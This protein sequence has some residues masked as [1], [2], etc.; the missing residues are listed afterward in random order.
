MACRG[1]EPS[2]SGQDS[3][4][5]EVQKLREREWVWSGRVPCRLAQRRPESGGVPRG[6]GKTSFVIWGGETVPG[7]TR[8]PRREPGPLRRRLP[9][10]LLLRAVSLARLLVCPT[11]AAR[12]ARWCVAVSHGPRARSYRVGPTESVPSL[13]GRG[14]IRG[15]RGRGA[16]SRRGR[17]LCDL[18][19]VRPELAGCS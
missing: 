10:R 15:E 16:G 7:H 17:V 1:P 3:Q 5:P 18:V 13:S 8:R 2:V 19:R 6:I 11:P 9:V 4:H 12:T 14:S